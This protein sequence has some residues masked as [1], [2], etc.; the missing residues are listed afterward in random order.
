MPISEDVQLGDGVKIWHPDLVNLYG[1]RIGAGT[2]IGPFVEIQKGVVIG[3][4]CTIS[5]HSFICEGVT[6]EDKVF[7]GHGV[8]FVN[9]KHPQSSR[10]D[11]I[12]PP[13]NAILVKRGAMI[14]T[15][16]IIMP[17]VTIGLE[18][19]VGAGARVLN[20][21]PAFAVVITKVITRTLYQKD[22][23]PTWWKWNW[24]EKDA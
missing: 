15:G 17:G 12:L 23:N 21:V 14:G 3:Q 19:E 9:E 2:K 7:I 18:A 5:S 22:Y 20:D 16:A 13:E 11:W 1:C 8:R 10:S 24:S 4:N 6:I